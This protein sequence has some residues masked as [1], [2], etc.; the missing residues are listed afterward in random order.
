DELDLISGVYRVFTGNGL[1]TSASSWWP[2]HSA[3]QKGALNVGYWS[4][5]CERWFQ[6]RLEMIRD[7]KAD[8]R[9]ANEWKSALVKNKRT[10]RFVKAYNEEV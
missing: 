3:W 2:R 5:D 6:K 9:S 8:L 1:Q 4:P 7:G 10:P